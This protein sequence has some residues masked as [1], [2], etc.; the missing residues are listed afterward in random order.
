MR[1]ELLR[2]LNRRAK[3][4]RHRVAARVLELMGQRDAAVVWRSRLARGMFN[5]H[6]TRLLYRTAR[7]LEG[8][9]DIAEIGSWMGRTSI[10]LGMAVRDSGARR[11]IYAIDPHTGSEEHQDWIRRHGSTFYDFQRNVALAGVSGLIEPLVM[12]SQDGAK[13]LRERGAR[14]RMAFIDGAHDEESV[15]Q[16][17]RSFL[18]LVLPRGVIAF[19]DCE[20]AGGF[21]GV[22]R[23]FQSELAP[24][25]DVVDHVHS[26]LVCRLRATA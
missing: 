20:E 3:P 5:P 6:E 11:T 16:D 17:I 7:A 19:H 8:D 9:G 4:L 1:I 2:D 25:V 10:I 13:I 26:L 15:R 14:L 18:P 23:A 22:W 12:R 21:P 24:R